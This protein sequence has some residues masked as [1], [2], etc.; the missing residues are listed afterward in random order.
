M[1]FVCQDMP[2]IICHLM[3]EVEKYLQKIRFSF[4][5]FALPSLQ[6]NQQ[7]TLKFLKH[8]L[9]SFADKH[10]PTGNSIRRLQQ[11]RHVFVH[12]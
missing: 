3:L 1:V 6:K 5:K 10:V 7:Q 8:S 12:G 9:K 11:L 2:A 4:L